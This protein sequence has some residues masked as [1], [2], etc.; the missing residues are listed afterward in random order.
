MET[1]RPGFFTMGAPLLMTALLVLMLVTFTLLRL[2]SAR[3]E[4]RRAHLLQQRS[5]AYYAACNQAEYVLDQLLHN[6]E[7]DIPVTREGETLSFRIPI[8]EAQSLTVT[9]QKTNQGFRVTSW[10]A[11][12]LN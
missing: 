11:E 8:D 6:E 12:N 10:K 9:L 3:E 5:D 4:Q 7:P 2:S 1:K